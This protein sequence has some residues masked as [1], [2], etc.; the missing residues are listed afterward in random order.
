M[1]ICRRPSRL[2]RSRQRQKQWSSTQPFQ[3][4]SLTTLDGVPGFISATVTRPFVIGF[5]PVVGGYPELHQ[6]SNWAAS[7]D[8]Q[9]LSRI[10]QSQANLKNKSLQKYLR[11]AERAEKEGNKR[12]ARANYQAAIGIA[13]EPLRSELR[14]RMK[15][16]LRR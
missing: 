3:S 15:E 14:Q 9:T 4:A 7:L 8:Q 11:R 5:T 13:A 10:R 12:M 2:H 16:M 1:W 6:Q